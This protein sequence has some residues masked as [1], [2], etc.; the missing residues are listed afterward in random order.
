METVSSATETWVNIGLYISYIMLFCSIILIVAWPIVHALKNP[1]E[2]KKTGMA[3]ASLV[4]LFLISYII[5]GSEVSQACEK[6][7][8]DSGDSKMVGGGLIMM[9]LLFIISIA[10]ILFTEINTAIK[11]R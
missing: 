7:N 3:V 11:R 6:F 1:Q 5:S 2:L 9:Y 10:G 8:L 4:V